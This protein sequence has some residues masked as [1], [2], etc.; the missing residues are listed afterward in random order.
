M[1]FIMFQPYFGMNTIHVFLYVYPLNLPMTSFPQFS[2]ALA[3]F[4]PGIEQGRPSRA[5]F[6]WKWC[7]RSQGERRESDEERTNYSGDVI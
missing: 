2:P 1:I 5:T 4:Q 3:A 7:H 6:S